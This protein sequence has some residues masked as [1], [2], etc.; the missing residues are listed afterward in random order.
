VY[1]VDS[2]YLAI[3]LKVTVLLEYFQYKCIS[4]SISMEF[5]IIYGLQLSEKFIYPN[6]FIVAKV[7]IT[8][9]TLCT[10]ICDPCVFVSPMYL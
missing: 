1:T 3:E 7:W 5:C 6:T 2:H 10:S 4:I 8:E 9:V